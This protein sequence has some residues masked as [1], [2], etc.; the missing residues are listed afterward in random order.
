MRHDK[1]VSPA[2]NL[3]PRQAFFSSCWFNMVHEMSLDSYRV[4]TMNPQ[5]ILRELLIMFE[6]HAND[7]D[8]TRVAQE[9]LMVLAE[10]NILS[11]SPYSKVTNDILELLGAAVG[12]KNA[13]RGEEVRSDSDGQK[14][15]G[16]F[17]KFAPLIQALAR[18]LL[19]YIDANFVLSSLEW[20][21]RTINNPPD[22]NSTA[23]QETI[24]LQSIEIVTGN[25]LSVLLDRGWSLESLFQLHQWMLVPAL[26]LKVEEGKEPK[27]YVFARA[28]AEVRARLASPPKPYT[29]VFAVLNV[30]KPVLFPG[31]IADIRFQSAP[32]NV[33]EASNDYAK[34]YAKAAGN[35]LF[36]TVT[37]AAQDGREAGMKA[38]DKISHILD[39]VRFEYERKDILLHEQFL[40]TKDDGR[41]TRLTIPKVVPNPETEWQPAELEEF[42]KKLED[43]AAS[44]T[45]PEDARDRIYS[46]FR[47]Y[48]VGADTRNFENKLVNW[49][50]AVEFLVKGGSGGGAIGD[51]VESALVPTL[52]LTYVPKHLGAFKLLLT[53]MRVAIREP[54][55]NEEINVRELSLIAFYKLL[56]RP[57][58][59]AVFTAACSS[60]PYLWMKLQPFIAALKNPDTLE[61][62]MCAHEEKLGWN[63]QRIYRAR[64]DIVHS[65]QRRVNAALLCAHLEFYLKGVLRAFLSSLHSVPTLRDPKEFFERQRYASARVHA[66]LKKKDVKSLIFTFSQ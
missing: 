58:M 62:M 20:L 40:L 41:C 60:A 59:E 39:L 23:A 55:T 49:W 31:Q 14:D 29:V 57:E 36:A 48:R 4:R 44:G 65:A 5:N 8:R 50:T 53:Q 47:L 38:S 11:E 37:V 3:L 15:K 6:A 33:G 10:R 46:A 45:L 16:K 30:S 21:D 7:N 25:L 61:A 2:H 51:G 34:S 35:K 56:I 43:L 12:K 66:D 26:P 22:P 17:A 32:P 19:H 24:A 42:V 28:F 52:S 13:A 9:A 54:Q 63:I 64:C 1:Q 18:E 27:L